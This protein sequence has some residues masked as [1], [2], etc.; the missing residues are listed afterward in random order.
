VA[1]ASMTSYKSGTNDIQGEQAASGGDQPRF[2]MPRLPYLG[3]VSCRAS[4]SARRVSLP[5]SPYLFSGVSL[6]VHVRLCGRMSLPGSPYLF[7]GVS[8]A[9]CPS[10]LGGG[11][12]LIYRA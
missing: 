8:L 1:P 9:V 3:G 11:A 5:G 6:A 2:W 10:L 4:V 7:S 12:A